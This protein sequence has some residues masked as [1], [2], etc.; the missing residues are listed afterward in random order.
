MNGFL[1]IKLKRIR[2]LTGRIK[3]RR[4]YP[5]DNKG[6]GRHRGTHWT[7]GRLIHEGDKK[8]PEKSF[9]KKT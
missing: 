8:Y 3:G 2:N 6:S 9:K 5:V 7:I 1:G 4:H